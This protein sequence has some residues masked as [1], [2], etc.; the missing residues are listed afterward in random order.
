[1]K[2]A[3]TW[4]GSQGVT[5]TFHDYKA[6]GI[7]VVR[8]KGW[9][10]RVGWQTLLNTRGTT[11]RKLTPAQQSHMDEKKALD[12]MAAQPSLIKRPVLEHGKTIVVGFSPERYGVAFGTK[13]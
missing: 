12:L 10:D 7:D 13:A 4:L 5:Y 6:A 3:F 9:S 11:W 1:M 8:L 2:K